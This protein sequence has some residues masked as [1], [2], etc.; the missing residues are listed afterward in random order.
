MLHSAGKKLVKGN[1]KKSAMKVN[2]N[3]LLEYE[4]LKQNDLRFTH[5]K[6]K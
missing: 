5:T 6:K 4:C 2:K 3:A 1:F